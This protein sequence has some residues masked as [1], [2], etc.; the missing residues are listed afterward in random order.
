M[1]RAVSILETRGLILGFAK[2]SRLDWYPNCMFLDGR[3]TSY[4]KTT[5]QNVLDNQESSLFV[6][7]QYNYQGKGQTEAFFLDTRLQ[8]FGF[9]PFNSQDRGIHFPN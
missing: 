1:S 2:M 7:I 4:P 9:L 3:E 6:L 5:K 8:A